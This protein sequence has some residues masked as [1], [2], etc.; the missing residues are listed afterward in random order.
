MSIYTGIILIGFGDLSVLA[1]E[2]AACF[3]GAAVVTARSLSEAPEAL[4]AGTPF[5]QPVY[6]LPGVKYEALR[7]ETKRHVGRIGLGKPLL[8]NESA[9]G[10][11]GGVLAETCENRR[12]LFVGHGTGARCAWMYTALQAVLHQRSGGRT[13][14][15]VLDGAPG[16]AAARRWII[17]HKIDALRLAPL[18]MGL[19]RHAGADILSGAPGS[20]RARLAALGVGVEAVAKG[21]LDYPAVREMFID[22]L[23]TQFAPPG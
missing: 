22:V 1:A 20:V 7:Q 10:R 15:S 8:R 4:G 14:V 18:T 12:T 5:V 21:L 23:K 19:G 16:W 13:C 9:V 17:D 11:L 3:P 2:T 6:L